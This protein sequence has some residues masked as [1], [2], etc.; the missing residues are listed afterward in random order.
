VK[1]I[2][3]KTESRTVFKRVREVGEWEMLVKEYIV[4]VTMDE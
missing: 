2:K 1:S 3:Q 4:A